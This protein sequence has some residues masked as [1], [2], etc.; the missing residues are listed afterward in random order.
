M[1]LGPWA[2]FFPRAPSAHT[3]GTEVRR[4]G[5]APLRARI[6]HST[7]SPSRPSQSPST[8]LPEPPRS[9]A[10]RPDRTGEQ[11]DAGDA[12]DHRR[13]PGAGHPDV[14]QRPPQA[15]LH[16]PYS[17][18]PLPSPLPIA[19]SFLRFVICLR[20]ACRAPCAIRTLGSV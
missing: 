14:L 9:R 17:P 2:S 15:P 1:Y 16:A 20:I 5:K 18:L 10:V 12:D 8:P 3:A 4:S 11:Q 6:R 7:L 19:R 13:P